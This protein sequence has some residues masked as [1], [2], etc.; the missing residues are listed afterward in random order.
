LSRATGNGGTAAASVDVSLVKTLVTAGPFTAGQSISYTLVVANAGP[1]T[2]TS[3]QVTDTPTNMTITIVTGGG[4]AACRARSPFAIAFIV[5]TPSAAFSRLCR[6][7][8]G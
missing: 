7:P 4:C 3:I 5:S 8:P 1:S 6:A 2:A